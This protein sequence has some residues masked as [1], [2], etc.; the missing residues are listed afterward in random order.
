MKLYGYWRSTST[1]RVRIALGLKG[2]RYEYVPVHLG[3]GEQWTDGFGAVNPRHEV[4]VLEVEEQGRL[5]HLAQSLAIIE[6]LEE[7]H[8]APPLLP[9]EPL[10]RARA[11]QLAEMVN[12]GIQP[13]QNLIVMNHVRDELHG[14]EKAWTRHWIARGLAALELAA[15]ETAGHFLVGDEV[16]YADVYLVPQLYAARRFDVALETCPTLTRVEATCSELPA[17]REAHASRQSD[18]D[19]KPA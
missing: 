14:D 9:R 18:A 4:P 6:Y 15:R 13:L 2:L 19:P 10:A 5:H 8:P 11:R 3:R 7:R 1:W 17:F 12:A 16:S